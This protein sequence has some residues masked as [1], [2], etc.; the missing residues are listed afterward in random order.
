M[1][2]PTEQQI[3]ELLA[4]LENAMDRCRSIL[5]QPHPGEADLREGL[6]FL[7][8]AYSDAEYGMAGVE[9]PD[10]H[11]LRSSAV[12]M[13]S[14]LLTPLRNFNPDLSTW[15]RARDPGIPVEG[16]RLRSGGKRPFDPKRIREIYES[17]K[18]EINHKL[19]SLPP[20][21]AAR[22]PP[23]GVET[24]DG[25]KSSTENP[26][27]L[28]RPEVPTISSGQ[29]GSEGVRDWPETDARGTRNRNPGRA[30]PPSPPGYRR[31]E[32]PPGGRFPMATSED[33]GGYDDYSDQGRRR[34]NGRR[35]RFEKNDKY[36]HHEDDLDFFR[37]AFEE[38]MTALH[39]LDLGD[40]FR[41]PSDKAFKLYFLEFDF[42]KAMRSNS[43]RKWDGT[44]RDYPNFKHNYYRM[45]F[46]QREHYMHKILAL[47]QMVPDSIKK[48]LFH[49]LHNTVPDLGH[50]L[51][52][53]EDRYGGQEKQL[54]QIIN[55]LQKL[56]AKGKVPYPD[57]R[58][59]VEDVSA[60][61]DRPSTLAGAGETLVVLL[62]KLVPKHFRTQFSDAMHQWGRPRTGNNF[63]AY[64]K[65]RLNYEMDKSEDFD[66]KDTAKRDE[67]SSKEKK[68]S[69]KLLGKMY[70]AD[71]KR[72]DVS[73][74]WNTSGSSEDEGACCLASGQNRPVPTCRCCDSGQHHLHGCRKFFI[75]FTLKDR[76]AF[77]RQQKVCF[78][79]LR[80]DHLI[81]QCPFKAKPDCRFCASSRH[82]YLLC[83]GPDDGM[84]K[85]AEGQEAL[86]LKEGYGLENIG[87]LIARRNV[88]TMQMVAYIEGRNGKLIPVNVLPDTGSCHN[89]LDKKAADR[90]GLTG[91]RC[92]YR[93]TAHGGHVTEHDAV[94]GE[95]TLVNYKQPGEKHTIRYYS[96]ENRCGPFFPTDWNKMK[97]GWPHLK[98]LD[99]PAPIPDQPVELILGCENLKLFEGIKPSSVRGPT[100]PI[101]R[102]TVIGW[103]V[104]GRTHP[105]ASVDVEGDSRVVQG[106]VGII[107]GNSDPVVSRAA[108][109]NVTNNFNKDSS[110]SG[111][112]E[113]IG[114]ETTR[115][116]EFEKLRGDL[117]R[118]WEL[119]TEEEIK[120]LTNS[121]SPAIRS[122][123]QKKA[124]AMLLDNLVQ[125]NDGQY[126]TKLLWTSDRRPHNNYAEARRAFLDWE[127][128]LA[129][130][131]RLRNAFHVAMAN[132]I[133]S[134]YLENT[135]NDAGSSQNFLTTF[136]VLK[137]EGD[138]TKARLVVNGARKFKGE[139]LNDFLE[140]GSNMM[141]DL[142]DL[143]LRLRRHRYAVSCD[144]ANMFLNIKVRV[145]DRSYLRI[146][147]R[148]DPSEEMQVYQFKVHA[149]G[150]TSSPCVAMTVV[151][152]HAKR[153][154]A[155]WPIAEKAVRENSLVDDIWLMSDSWSELVQGI[156]EIQELMTHMGIGVHKWGSNCPELLED[157]PLER[158]AKEIRL[159]DNEGVA[160][161]ALGLIWDTER[162]VFIFPEGPPDLSPWSLRR[163]TSAAGQLFDPLV[164]LGPATLPAK[165]LIQHAWRYQ[166]SWYEELP[167][168]LARKMS[169]Y[170]K[171]QRQLNQVAVPR[172]LGGSR[173]KDG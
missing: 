105:E 153:H 142:S 57:L 110:V 61:L 120:K 135:E 26:A 52:R 10:W 54:K 159:S 23:P 28:G 55:D 130:D 138:D 30:G 43:L 100:D 165:L 158:R 33:D 122:A 67:S 6:C 12:K 101:A 24:S 75:E 166:G 50:R 83:P 15:E 3:K 155:R 38:E 132:W 150:L 143:L 144:L 74:D 60:Y 1:T 141:S 41:Y 111:P 5:K 40:D 81:D 19:R 128:R 93:V 71:G 160:I 148:C 107:G 29:V 32:G 116:E 164:F 123:R 137:G 18:R 98:P 9:R 151:Q 51:R 21:P 77:A 157:I 152:T 62:K 108:T 167:E 149:F 14:L 44:I 124:E 73:S 46:V 103:M 129:S 126:Q 66:K 45:V 94:C 36:G 8:Y 86:E 136:M 121:Y 47:E 4:V 22:T 102:L 119:E 11:T 69:P 161:K 125:L 173:G 13:V 42:V 2:N 163:M 59:A 34:R 20:R 27:G 117:H 58:R 127:R 48:E 109:V 17:E 35:K 145:E 170:C 65:R 91:I 112:L 96:Y 39:H 80:Y 49:G 104:G 113:V 53:L 168:C 88:S 63:V 172:H 156:K 16:S 169:L 56:G 79:C 82:H 133:R 68:L 99:I 118:V 97:G 31:D 95:L 90:A 171:N 72:Q 154:G 146:F 106:I 162:D 70:Q 85:A 92:K 140:P 7:K 134:D 87:E 78:K 76:V 89:I 139:C 64:L 115:E 84:V 147:Y 114:K 131:D 25:L 37:G